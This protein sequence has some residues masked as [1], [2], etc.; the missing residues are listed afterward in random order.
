MGY[1]DFD[2]FDDCIEDSGSGRVNLLYFTCLE[3][4]GRHILSCFTCLEGGLEGGWELRGGRMFNEAVAIGG[5]AKESPS[6]AWGREEVAEGK[7]EGEKPTP[8]APRGRGRRR[9][10]GRAYLASCVLRLMPANSYPLPSHVMKQGSYHD[11][12]RGYIIM[13]YHDDISS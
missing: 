12:T 7:R 8:H 1:D 4:S 13:R 6:R 3:G 9:G 2:E 11:I 5:S 10:E